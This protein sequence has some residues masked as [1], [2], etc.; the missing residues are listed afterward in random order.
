MNNIL[1]LILCELV[2]AAFVREVWIFKG[3]INPVER[4]LVT[5]LALLPVVGWLGA[6]EFLHRRAHKIK[7]DSRAKGAVGKNC[8][9]PESFWLILT[10]GG[11]LVAVTLYRFWASAGEIRF[12]GQGLLLSLV[13]AP[14]LGCFLSGWFRSGFEAAARWRLHL[15]WPVVKSGFQLSAVLLVAAVCLYL[16]WTRFG[17]L[18]VVGRCVLGLLLL[19]I[20]LM[21]T[22]NW[23]L[24]RQFLRASP[25][26]FAPPGPPLDEAAAQADRDRLELL[27]L[28]RSEMN[29][30]LLEEMSLAEGGPD[31]ALNLEGLA[32]ILRTG[33]V[34][35]PLGL[36]PGGLCEFLTLT[37]DLQA[38]ERPDRLMRLFAGWVML[39]AY[40]WPE[41]EGQ[42]ITEQG[43]ERRLLVLIQ[44]STA[45]GPAFVRASLRFVSWA[46]S[47]GKDTHDSV[48]DL[49]YQ[50]TRLILSAASPDA[51]DVAAAPALYAE[52]VAK[53]Q[54]IRRKEAGQHSPD[55]PESEWLFGLYNDFEP[56]TFRREWVRAASLALDHLRTSGSAE[57]NPA[58]IELMKRLEARQAVAP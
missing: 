44:S 43:D 11:F 27:W 28:V 49:F 16:V 45:L 21:L 20:L 24:F 13:G 53:E 58:L 4:C 26:P 29:D 18:G 7:D 39:N 54:R 31:H 34:P 3:R 9:E 36:W 30:A 50:F 5:V 15:L 35:R 55:W 19:P 40:A 8:G 38:Q 52:L 17:P 51:A 33:R 22:V 32:E 2:S 42:G 37:V 41:R 14:A 6:W 1:L 56:E 46:Q 47:Q 23:R 12:A 25:V 48:S 10:L 57:L